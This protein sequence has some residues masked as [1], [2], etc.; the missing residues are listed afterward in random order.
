MKRSMICQLL[1]LHQHLFQ[2]QRLLLPLP[3]QLPQLLPPQL[4]RV[5]SQRRSALLP[6]RLN[7]IKT[8][9]QTNK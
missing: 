5:V 8:N 6:R 4:L 2:F 7:K 9:N 1:R 3:H